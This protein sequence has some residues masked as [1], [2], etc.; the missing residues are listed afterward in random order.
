MEAC[1]YYNVKFAYRIF[2]NYA[3]GADLTYRASRAS[4]FDAG[5]L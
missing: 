2:T 1:T 5:W 4:N 3:G